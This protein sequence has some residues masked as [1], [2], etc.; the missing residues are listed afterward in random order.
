MFAKI[1]YMKREN[2]NVREY[3]KRENKKDTL[4]NI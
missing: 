3:M 2:K 4:K 1:E